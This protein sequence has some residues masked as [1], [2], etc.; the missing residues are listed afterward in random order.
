M[1]LVEDTGFDAFDARLP[2]DSWRQQLGMPGYC[3]DQTRDKMALTGSGRRG[4]FTQA[5]RPRNCS[6]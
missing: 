5:T 2:S 1:D 4:A 3:T 6:D